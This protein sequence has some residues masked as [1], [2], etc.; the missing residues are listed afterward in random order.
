MLGT[1]WN[2]EASYKVHRD[3]TSA[4]DRRS[5]VV[6]PLALTH[7]DDKGEPCTRHPASQEGVLALALLGSRM[8]SFHHEAA[9]KLDSLVIA[10][11][12]LDA[13]AET[14]P[15][16][17]LA[18]EAIANA[19]RDLRQLLS[20]NRTMSTQPKRERTPISAI[21]AS[22][23]ER[24]SV[25]LDGERLPVEVEVSR[26]SVTH[27][28]A[29]MLDLVAGSIALGRRVGV[30]CTVDGNLVSIVLAGPRTALAKL[31]LNA[32]T[33]LT[34]ATYAVHREGGEMR[35]GDDRFTVRLPIAPP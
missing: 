24:A 13:I 16:L 14:Q 21:L 22:A 29:V 6:E 33:L 3:P 5:L 32:N 27:A 2:I 12:E 31:P 25:D 23:A 34:I 26:P 19:V 7:L 20:A 18:T 8:P 15:E 10:L 1:P 35:C 11:D 28:L 17:R 30:T 4:T 9:A